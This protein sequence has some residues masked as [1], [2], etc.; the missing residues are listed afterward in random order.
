M[1]PFLCASSL[2]GVYLQHKDEDLMMPQACQ[3]NHRVILF[4]YTSC[5]KTKAYKLQLQRLQRELAPTP[6][7]FPPRYQGQR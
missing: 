5:Q 2:P 7:L 6:K 4:I 3:Y 1:S